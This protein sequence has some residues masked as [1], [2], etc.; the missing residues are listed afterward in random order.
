MMPVYDIAI[1]SATVILILN[2]IP[3]I[4]RNFK[5]KRTFSQSIIREVMHVVGISILIWAYLNMGYMFSCYLTVT[6]MFTEAI[7]IS[8]ILV[9]R[10]NDRY[11]YDHVSTAPDFVEDGAA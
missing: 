1:A 8:Q 2:H 6:D 11:V 5:Y 9:W 10:E 3:Q 4:I 7:L